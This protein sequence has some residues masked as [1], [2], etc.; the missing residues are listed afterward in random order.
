MW[1]NLRKKLIHINLFIFS[2]FLRYT[3]NKQSFNYYS[4]SPERVVWF[5]YVSPCIAG[6][7]ILASEK[8][9]KQKK[10]SGS[11]T[12]PYNKNQY[13]W[14]FCRKYITNEICFLIT[15]FTS[16]ITKYKI[17]WSC[18]MLNSCYYMLLSAIVD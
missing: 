1:P 4:I 7:E 2:I 5:P 12:D 17:S 3:P 13:H 16:N 8:Y 6:Y 10:D 11:C 9:K 18:F 14:G 15:I